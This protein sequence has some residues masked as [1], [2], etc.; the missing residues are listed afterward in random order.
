MNDPFAS[1]TLFNSR[2]IGTPNMCDSVL[3][4]LKDAILQVTQ[5]MK[6]RFMLTLQS[7]K[8]LSVCFLLI[9]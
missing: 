2:R 5:K 8:W 9:E 3:F 1:G 7:C 4:P 6:T